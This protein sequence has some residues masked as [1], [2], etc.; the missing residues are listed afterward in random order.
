M[1]ILKQMKHR[2]GMK[3]KSWQAADG[4]LMHQLLFGRKKLKKLV[5]IKS[6]IPE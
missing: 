5:E 3:K 6:F 4:L 2:F 1:I